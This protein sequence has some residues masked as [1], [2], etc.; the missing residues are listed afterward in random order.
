MK[1]G[2]LVIDV[3]RCHG[4]CN[5][6]MA[7]KDEFVGNDFPPY[8]ISQPRHGQRWMNVQKVE[9]G[10]YPMVDVA[11]LP[12]PCQHCENAPCQKAGGKAVLHQ[13]HYNAV[14]FHTVSARGKK[15]I[16]D[17]CPYHA[18]FWNEEEQL[19]QKCNLCTHLL[20]HAWDKPRCVMACPTQA[21][22]FHL[23]DE[24]KMD[25][26]IQEN[27]LE[28]YHPE[29]HTRP[30]VFYKNLYRFTKHFI[31][32]AV[33]LDGDCLEGALVRCRRE[34]ENE[35]LQV[36]TNTY[37]EFRV[38]RLEDGNY[39]LEITYPGCLARTLTAAVNGAS[40]ICGVIEV[41]RAPAAAGKNHN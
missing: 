15:E 6:F 23:V 26:F 14:I 27:E 8:S 18:A 17:A 28:V 16:A 7:C 4:C 40:A 38:D 41:E 10:R 22:T 33:V 9:R 30:H 1:N 25:A 35:I 32:G 31:G 39:E 12:T 29:Y 37:G 5:C 34:G 21:L 13:E 19:A 3:A 24:E 20:E 36:Y 2:V 11:F